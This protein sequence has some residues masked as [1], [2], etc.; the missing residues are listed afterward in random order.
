MLTCFGPGILAGITFRDW[1]RLL[2]EHRFAVAPSC[3]PR[4]MS[5]T[6]HSLRNSV[7]AARER[8]RFGP[9]LRDLSV[10]PPLFVLGHWRHGT[11][12]LHN[13]LAQDSRFAFANIYQASFPHTFLSTE[14]RDAPRVD[15]FLPGQRPMDNVA[16]DIASPQEDEF[17]LCVLT[18]K[19]PCMG[20]VFPRHRHRYDRYLTLRG[21][22]DGE[23]GE[24]RAAFVGFLKKLTWRYGRP[25]VLKSPP[26]TGR[27]RLLSEMF[28]GARFV[29]IHRDPYV[30]FQ[31]SRRTFDLTIGWHC[32]QRARRDESDDWVIGQY[33]AMYEAFF[34]ERGL[35]PRG[36]FHEV[37]F[38]DLERD[39]IAE[40]RKTYE[41][42]ELPAFGEVEGELRAYVASLTGYRKNTFAPLPEGLRIRIASEW[43]ACFEAWGY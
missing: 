10:P 21:L 35:V 37:A 6:L 17:A 33:R 4:A 11:T 30:V 27:I 12:H 28:P 19:S 24:W 18:R 20:W 31:S 43:K 14:A 16:W 8:R 22:S 9:D 40:L 2:R 3:L 25:L 23:L 13:L 32:L 7:L 1:L 41:A 29:H 26:H 34:E 39:P 5:I 42:L 15:F 36:R 38:E